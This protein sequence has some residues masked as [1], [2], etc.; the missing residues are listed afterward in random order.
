MVDKFVEGGWQMLRNSLRGQDNT[1]SLVISTISELYFHE[2]G[3]IRNFQG[4]HL[5][6]THI[7]V[8]LYLKAFHKGNKLNTVS[9]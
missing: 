7:L 8:S 2:S 4:K 1:F 9:Y 6:A 5:G 3:A